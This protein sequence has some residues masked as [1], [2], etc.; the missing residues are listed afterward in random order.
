MTGTGPPPDTLL[1]AAFRL[2]APRRRGVEE[3]RRRLREKGFE[4]REVAHCLKWL[5]EREL[6]DDEAF[7]QALTRDRVRFSPRS[8]SLLH[9][10]L[11]LRGIDPS[12]AGS[13]VEAVLE[14]EGTSE[15]DLAARAALAADLG[16][17]GVR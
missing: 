15:T 1:H 11:A 10:E 9:R 7:A 16:D 5:E 13:A 17:V 12:V 14:A 4:A 6:L 8:A 2:L 3:L